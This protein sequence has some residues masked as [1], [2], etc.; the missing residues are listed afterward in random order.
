MKA[1]VAKKKDALK[2]KRKEKLIANDLPK[3]RA[4]L[5]QAKRGV[6]DLRRV[7]DALLINA[8]IR[9]GDQ[10]E[11]DGE[12]LGWRMTLPD[13]PVEE[14]LKKYTLKAEKVGAMYVLGVFEKD[15]SSG[16]EKNLSN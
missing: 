8:A 5:Y 16:S 3:L 7:M 10:E 1:R 9:Y 4:E 15:L 6:Y 14:T 2:Q 11:E 12:V 13:D